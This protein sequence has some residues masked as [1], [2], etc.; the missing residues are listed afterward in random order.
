MVSERIVSY[1][2]FV[3]SIVGCLIELRAVKES[4]G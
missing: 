4:L 1:K 2:E 3:I